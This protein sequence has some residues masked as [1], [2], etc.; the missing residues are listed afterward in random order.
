MCSG[1]VTQSVNGARG[2]YD[3]ETSAQ[4]K[5]NQSI[6]GKFVF[7]SVPPSSLCE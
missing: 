5:A 1:V 4:Q 6:P 3:R 2:P 7:V